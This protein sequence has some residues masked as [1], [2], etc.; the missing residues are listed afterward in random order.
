MGEHGSA[1][2]PHVAMSI[3]PQK[4]F[5]KTWQC[6]TR[7]DLNTPLLVKR[8]AVKGLQVRHTCITVNVYGLP[9]SQVDNCIVVARKH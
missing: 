3:R 2:A 5:A 7:S 4:S 1:E 8:A 6:E 9:R